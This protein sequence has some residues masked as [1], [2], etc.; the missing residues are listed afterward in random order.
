MRRFLG[1]VP[2]LIL[3]FAFLGPL[4]QASRASDSG[5]FDPSTFGFGGP[6]AQLLLLGTFHFKDAGLD[7]YKPKHDIDILSAERQKELGEIL[8]RLEA[9]APTRIAVEWKRDD[10]ARLD[11][12]YS[13]YLAGE[14]EISSNEIYQ[15]GFRLGKRLG[16]KKLHAVDAPM[17]HYDP[18]TDSKKWAKKNDQKWIYD[19][20]WHERFEKLYNWEDQRKTTVPLLET[21]LHMNSPERLALGHGHYLVGGFKAGDGTDYPGADHLS[22]W[23]YVRNLRIFSNLLQLAREEDDRVLFL[24]GA[25]HVPI[26]RHAAQS[27]PDV[28]LVEVSE[29]L[30]SGE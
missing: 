10:Q 7:G 20:E 13:Q 9:F 14:Y 17:R 29:V 24:V 21:F 12:R 15:I 23:W 1:A 4:V 3:V 5:D 2:A 25:G 6:R 18:W 26:I 8:D 27:A 16:H 28:E 19:H 22:G 11:E 30:G